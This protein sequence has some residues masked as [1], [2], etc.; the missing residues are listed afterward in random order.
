MLASPPVIVEGDSLAWQMRPAV[1]YRIHVRHYEAIIGLGAR[2]GID[3]VLARHVA[4]R[5]VLVSLGTNDALYPRLR[6]LS[7]RMIARNARRLVRVAR[8]VVWSRVRI[9]RPGYKRETRIAN[10]GLER[11]A[12]AHPRLHLIRPPPP[13]SGDGVH[14]SER[15]ARILG[16]RFARAAVRECG[17]ARRRS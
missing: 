12:R 13:D 1:E 8:C 11:V 17:A 6:H 4:G 9:A 10:A 3:R 5:I 14:F 15:G 7:S 16:S 2:L